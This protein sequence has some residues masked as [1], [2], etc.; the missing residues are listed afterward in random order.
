M[1]T[2]IDAFLSRWKEQYESTEKVFAVLTDASLAQPVADDHR[3]LGRI[4]WH[5]VTTIPEMMNKTGLSVA[6]VEEDAPLVTTA[7]EIAAGYSACA[8]ELEKAVREGWTDTDLEVED[9]MYGGAWKRGYTVACL[10]DHEIHHVGQM[11]VLMRQA[12]LRVPGIYGPAM[13]DWAQFGMTAPEV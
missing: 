4:A 3:T 13:E 9:S 10:V 1:F 12:G 5:L 2:S 11:S 8:R 7:V 6:S